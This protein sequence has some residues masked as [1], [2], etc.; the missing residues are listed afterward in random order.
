MTPYTFTL[1]HGVTPI[2]GFMFG[3]DVAALMYHDPYHRGLP[4]HVQN[5]EGLVFIPRDGE[6]EEEFQLRLVMND[7]DG[8]KT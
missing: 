1:Y 6:T 8:R 2:A 3:S 5:A 7:H 4:L